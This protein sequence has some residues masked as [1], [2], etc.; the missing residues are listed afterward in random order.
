MTES[1]PLQNLGDGLILRRGAIEDAERLGQFN[2]QIHGDNP[3]DAAGVSAWTRDL[4]IGTH[5][6]FRPE[7]FLIV[8][9]QT[10]GKIV[11]SVCLIDQV[12]AYE[13]VDFKVGRPELVG[14]DPAYRSR[15][16]VRR[17]FEILHQWSQERE[18]LVQAITGIPNYYRQF[19]YEMGLQLGGGRFGYEPQ[20]RPLKEGQEEP[21][22]I[23]LATETDISWLAKMYALEC[24]H[25]LVSA[26]WDEVLWCYEISG[27]SHENINRGLPCIIENGEGHP[28]GYL[29]HPG[30]PWGT[31]MPVVRFQ[32]DEGVAFAAVL[33]GV[34]RYLWKIGQEYCAALNRKLDTFGL[35]LGAD[36]PAYKI[37]G[38]DLRERPTYAFYMRVPNLPAFLKRI[39]PVLEARLHESVCAGHTGELKVSFYRAGV[40][41]V[42][43][44]G[45]LVSVENWK[46]KIREDEGNAAFPDLTFLQLMF[47][48]RNLD[49]IRYAYA[50]CWCSNE[51]AV[52]LGCLF[53]KKPSNVW[54]VS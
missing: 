53:P 20:V 52:L 21:Y 29:V 27:K 34:I 10:V 39:A 43:E 49:E 7:D 8:E 47:G 9:D 50:D 40:K 2:A 17:Q 4:A 31:M 35:W 6:T 18:Q 15:G 13:G 23:R 16:L 28:V 1:A 37:K 11:S 51:A 32:V 24:R 22:R 44:G 14:T 41:L 19:G 46:P 42:W 48:Y 30:G 45:K 33:P 54:V 26:V 3:Q 5:P 38:N 36:H 12:W 25:S